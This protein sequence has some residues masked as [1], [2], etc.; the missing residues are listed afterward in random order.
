MYSIEDLSNTRS[1]DSVTSGPCIWVQK[2]RANTKSCEVKDLLIKKIKKPSHQER[3]HKHTYPQYID[4]DVRA[5]EDRNPKD[6]EYLRQF[7]KKMCQLKTDAPAVILLLFIRLHYTS[8]APSELDNK[9]FD[10]AKTGIMNTKIQEIIRGHP[11]ISSKDVLRLLTFSDVDRDHVE[12]TTTMQWQCEEWYIHKAGFITA[13][14][15]KRVFT[16]QEAIEKNEKDVTKLVK[17]IVLPE[18]PHSC[19]QNQEVEPQNPREWGLFH[20]E[21][22]RR[23]YQRV[24]SHTHHKLELVS[25]GFLISKSKPFLG[26]S[27]DNIQRCQCSDG[28]PNKVL[29]YKC[30]WKHR[31]MHPKE[32]FLTPEIGGTVS[33]NGFALKPSSQYLLPTSASNVCE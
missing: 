27:V 25:K 22:A 8:E 6:E 3:K 31:D 19:G 26:A 28:C 33:K 23:A 29:E 9:P 15:C 20:E 32:A 17:D 11:N 7:T 16:R 21:S 12:R 4:R 2:P 18:S 1:K 5:P 13:S 24:A 14:R 30:P 10:K